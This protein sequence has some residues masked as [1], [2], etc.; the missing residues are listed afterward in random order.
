MVTKVLVFPCGTEVGL[1]I[2]RSLR[3]IRT[4]KVMGLSSVVDHGSV[5]FENYLGEV[6]FVHEPGFLQKFKEVLTANGIEFIFPAHDEVALK[7]AEWEDELEATLVSHRL[8]TLETLRSKTRTYRALKSKIPVPEVYDPGEAVDHLPVFV[9]PDRGQGSQGAFPVHS[10]EDFNA[11]ENADKLIICELLTGPEYTVDCLTNGDGKLV[12]AAGRCRERTSRG[13][14][15][16]TTLVENELFQEFAE[17]INH[18]FHFRGMWFFQLKADTE[19]ELKLLEVGTRLSGGMSLNR[20]RGVNLP[21]LS[22]LTIQGVEFE[23]LTNPG[24]LIL[25]R[26]LGNRFVNDFSYNR[27]YLDF[28]DTVIIQGK[29]NLDVMKFVY[30]CYNKGIDVVLL[31]RHTGAIKSTLEKYH[32]GGVFSQIIHIAAG[33]RKS[34]YIKPDGSVFVDDSFS[35]RKEVQERYK[36]PVFGPDNIDMLLESIT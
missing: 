12:Y 2:N 31:T 28:D 15:T 4:V 36:I 7:L 23:I 18:E 20:A 8:R 13:I 3:D 6:P 24:S 14:S 19:G 35:E 5:A 32:L 30:Q 21:L 29:I 11:L 22:M 10:R 1:E 33:V 16:R 27:V 26:A 34:D 9:K 25:E 17:K